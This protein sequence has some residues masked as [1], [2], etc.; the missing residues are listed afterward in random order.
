MYLNLAHAL[1]DLEVRTP[2]FFML[3][4]LRPGGGLQPGSVL[5]GE[6]P[7]E[8]CEARNAAIRTLRTQGD[9][10]AVLL[11]REILRLAAEQQQQG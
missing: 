11:L 4:A 8:E 3:E 5:Q 7:R 10:R 1:A 2:S 9:P 6:P